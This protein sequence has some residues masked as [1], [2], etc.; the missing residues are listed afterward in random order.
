MLQIMKSIKTLLTLVLLA[1]TVHLAEAQNAFL[2][3]VKETEELSKNC[4]ALFSDWKIDEM[5]SEIIKYTP[6][7]EEEM[8]KLGEKTKGF[9]DMLQESYG[10]VI[11]YEKIKN[12]TINDF[13][14]RETYV[15][16]L[17]YHAL[18]VVYTFY[19]NDKGWALN[20]FNWDDE[21]KEEF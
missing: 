14:I 5:M 4:T 2:K 17:E 19:K 16:R 12:E 9:Q 11:G 20:S 3:N 6:V 13:A 10:E 21:W 7:A 8:K 15:I 1:I 18:R